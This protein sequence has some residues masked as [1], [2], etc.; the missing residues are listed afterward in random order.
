MPRP[1]NPTYRDGS[2]GAD[3]WSKKQFVGSPRIAPV[4]SSRCQVT[5]SVVMK[6]PASPTANRLPRVERVELHVAQDDLC[7]VAHLV[8]IG[9]DPAVAR[10]HALQ[11]FVHLPGGAAVIGALDA[12]AVDHVEQVRVVRADEKA[13]RL[14]GAAL[15]G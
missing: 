12:I 13:L 11:A 14:A 8:A 9:R 10:D 4:S 6:A 15:P 1:A 7:R 5:P 3:H 2:D